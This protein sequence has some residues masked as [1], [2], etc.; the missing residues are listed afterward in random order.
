[1]WHFY[2]GLSN[3][4]INGKWGFVDKKGN[5][6]IEPKFEYASQ[7]TNGLAYAEINEKSGFINKNGTFVI[8]P[9]FEINKGSRFE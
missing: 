7:F 3:F 5:I 9:K 2:E 4:K 6:V 1:M 8:E